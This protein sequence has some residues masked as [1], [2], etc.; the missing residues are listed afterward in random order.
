M[1][2]GVPVTNT[3]FGDT[4]II[5]G[6]VGEGSG[7]VVY[8]AIHTRLNKEVVIKQI[9]NPNIGLNRNETDLLKSL[10]HSYLPQVLDFI[11]KDGCAYTV[12]D[13]IKGS[14]I[15]HLIRS[16]EKFSGKQIIKIATQL[17][18]AVSYLHSQK[19]PI[20]HSDIKPAN[21]MLSD[22]G[23]ICLIDFNVSLVFEKNAR[24]LGG[25]RGFAPPEQLGIPLD[26]IKNGINGSLPVGQVTPY[27]NER[28]D[29]YSIGAFIYFMIARETPAANYQCKPLTDF[30]SNIP[31]GLLHIVTKAMMLNSTKR[32]KNAGEM[33]SALKNIG[34]LDHR[35]KAMKVRRA[36]ATVLAVILMGTFVG[37]NRAGSR[38]MAEEHEEKYQGYVKQITQSHSK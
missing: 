18:E 25:T 23:N 17:C 27:V 1:I 2:T 11:E 14:D 30:N 9:I 20:I 5:I 24:T 4:Y 15:E 35:Y 16:G 7:G 32:Y 31:D 28:S 29:V 8:K 3:L 19:P 12:M 6:K 22:N 38:K 10:K 26:T 13:Y 36:I 33:L 37:L 21:V 34:R